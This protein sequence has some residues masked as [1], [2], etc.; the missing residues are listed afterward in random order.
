MGN[1]IVVATAQGYP[2]KKIIENI[3]NNYCDL[4]IMGSQGLDSRSCSLAV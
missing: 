3:E 4:I 2:E 1:Y